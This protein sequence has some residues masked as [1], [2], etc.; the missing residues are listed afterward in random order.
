MKTAYIVKGYRTAVGKAPK[1]VFRFKRTDELAAETIQFMMEKI[2]QLDKLRIDDVMVGNA[3]PE[4]AQGLNMGRF[5]SLMGLK[6][7]DVPGVTVNRFC[8]SG[9][10]TIAMATAKIQSGMANCIIAGGA[11]S[12]SAVPMSGYKT[13][14]SYDIAK[15]GHE[16]YYWGMGNTAEAVANKYKVSREDQDAFAFNSHMKALKAQEE[17]KFDEQIV[18]ITVNQIYVDEQ[19]KKS[20]RSYTVTKDE[21]PRA[22][23]SLEI[24]AKLPAVFAAGGSVTAGNSSQM[25]DAAAFVIVMSEEMVKELNLEPIARLVSYAAAGVEPS[26]MGI[27][28][29]KAIP[30]ALK[31]A[32]LKQEDISLIELNEAFASQS[33]AVIRE[34]GLN[35]DI[36]NVNGGA[37]ALGHPLGCTG[38]KLSVQLFDEMRKRNLNNK[39]GIVTMCVGTG[40]GAAGV[41][42]FLK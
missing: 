28:P 17:G 9:L 21:G 30:K 33:I 36:V 40:Q 2:P 32:G 7:I 14:L 20:T 1:G 26:L 42:E 41:Y 18:P 15:S 23:T 6:T 8:S 13:E 11:E 38:G 31:Q 16:D 27:G 19:G 39:Y 29:V 4:G 12:M 3:M 22:G 34:L 35:S 25:S 10:E 24:L 5:I 37:I